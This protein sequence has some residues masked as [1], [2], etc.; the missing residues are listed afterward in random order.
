MKY[1]LTAIGLTTC[2]YDSKVYTVKLMS[3]YKDMEDT[4]R[5]YTK[6]IVGTYRIKDEAYVYALELHNNFKVPIMYH[7]RRGQELSRKDFWELQ[8]KGLLGHLKPYR[9]IGLELPKE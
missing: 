8:L 2:Y 5:W 9:M 6:K 3:V 1:P 7:A 4:L